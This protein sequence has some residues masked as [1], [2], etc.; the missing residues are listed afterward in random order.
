MKPL[1]RKLFRDLRTLRWQIMSIA[2]VLACGV[3]VLVAALG[4]Y[5]SLQD[6][7]ADFY[8]QARFADLFVSLRRAPDSVAARLASIDGVAAVETRLVFDVRIDLPNA[9]RAVGA[10]AVSLPRHARSHLLVVR[11]RLPNEGARR[12][13]A[14]NEAF[15]RARQMSIG[16]TLPAILNGHREEL[17]IVGVV[18]SAEYVAVL[19]PG[20]HV[21][22][23]AHF[24]VIW[25]PQDALAAA[26]RAEGT[27]NEA[28]FW[29]AP[30]ADPRAVMADIDRILEPHGG[31]GAYERSEQPA[32]RF[33][34][35]ELEELEVMATVLPIIFFGV[36]IFLLNMVLARIIAQERT[37]IATLRALG[38]RVAPI[39]SHYLTLAIVIAGGGA[40][41]GVFLA[42]WLG[43]GLTDLY[44][45]FFTFPDLAFR[46][47]P[48]VIAFGVAVSLGAGLLG[49]LA[50]A[51]RLARLAPAEALQ[52]AAP[53]A[54]RAGWT[55]YS[56]MAK[57]LPVT[58]RLALRNMTSQPVRAALATTGV[59]SAMAVLVVGAFWVDAFN[60]L[61][62]Q[63][64]RWVMR[65]D[66]TVAFVEPNRDAAVRE[67]EHVPG[68]RFAEGFR[69]VPVR[70]VAGRRSKRVQ[71]LGLDARSRLR[72]LIAADGSRIEL[73]A[74]GVVLSGHLAKI[75]KV[76]RGQSVLLESLEGKRTRYMARV[77]AVVE[78]RIGLSIYMERSAVARL[79]DDGTNVS[80]ALLALEPGREKAI[81][82]S[83]RRFPGIATVLVK[84]SFVDEFQSSMMEVVLVFSLVLTIIGA[85][86]VVGVVYNAS[87]VLVSE[88]AN[89]FATLRVL[90]F[91]RGDISE[92]LLL[93]IAFQVLP[94]L[95]LGAAMGYGLC[96]LAVHL[97]G[98]EDL[99][100]PLVIGVRTLATALGV[101]LASS[102]V[103]ALVVRR[104]LDQL[105]L[106]STLKVRE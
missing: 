38:F 24:G 11:G 89:Q 73:G 2:V 98:P 85:L 51:R 67:L 29:L 53:K 1:T 52:P 45:D 78:E 80:G 6:A 46:A 103:A 70:V 40:I 16:D 64:F 41:A 17:V 94:A 66:A 77:A 28:V 56:A 44:R 97:F 49:A 59:A 21:P 35:G 22:D 10:R 104:R 13:V 88:R 61:L 55:H 84:Q 18:L 60:E 58:L 93:E 54:Y 87:R 8:R 90:G 63:Q 15:A 74:G 47:Q 82:S 76:G 12:E 57:R 95:L 79:V 102:A 65:E 19:R 37:Q 86:I 71:L 48:L 72:H 68:V 75:L 50:S 31:F 25:L 39:V 81:H 23:N 36:A 92:V 7:R 5:G 96:A 42:N 3:A 26:Y 27:F 33:V 43:S 34:Q 106:V 91:S 30:G 62:T 105:D 99:S 20:T 69:A 4:T 83:L 32:H 9:D 100:I 101:V 14:V